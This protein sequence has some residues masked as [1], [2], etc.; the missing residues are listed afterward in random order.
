LVALA[1]RGDFRRRSVHVAALQRAAP[2]SVAQGRVDRLTE[3]LGPQ[4]VTSGIKRS[5]IYGAERW[6]LRGR[7]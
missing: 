1:A 3:A 7:C 5:I 6:N 4:L 2:G